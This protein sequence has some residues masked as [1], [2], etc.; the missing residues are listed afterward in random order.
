[1]QPTWRRPDLFLLR[2]WSRAD[3]PGLGRAP[4][5]PGCARRSGVRRVRR[6]DRGAFLALVAFLLLTALVSSDAL[7][8]ALT[9]NA[10][11]ALVHFAAH[12]TDVDLGGRPV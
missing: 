10:A 8:T 1:M 3:H 5:Q 11:G 9:G 7:V 12:A 4:D 6:D 2:L